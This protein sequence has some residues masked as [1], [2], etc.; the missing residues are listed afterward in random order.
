M[1]IPL[2]T[3]C[4]NI[5]PQSTS[6]VLGAGASVPSGA[7]SGAALSQSIWELV[8]KSSA[9]SDDLV[10]SASILERRFGR[11]AVI[12]AVQ[13]TLQSLSPCGGLLGLPAFPWRQLF[14]TNF[15]RLVELAYKS[16][17]VPLVAMRS[18]YDLST[19]ESIGKTVLYKIHGCVTQDRSLG[20]KPSMVLTEEDYENYGQFRQSLFS[21]LKTALLT[22]DILVI[23]QSL[24]DRHLS[25]LVKEILKAK[26]EGAPGQVYVL[27]YDKDDLRAPLLEDKGARIAFGGIDQFVDALAQGHKVTAPLA[28]SSDEILP[29]ELLASVTDATKACA[30]TANVLRMFNGGAA[31]YADIKAL[32]TFER[33]FISDLVTRLELGS[34]NFVGIVGAAGV[35]KTTLCR[36]I[37]SILESKGFKG[38]E[39][40]EDFPFRY[41]PWIRVEADLRAQGKRGIL[42]LDE[43]THY[44]RAM[45]EL[46]D[47]LADLP[48]SALKIIF[49]ANAAQWAP[50]IKSPNIFKKGK[51]VELSELNESDIRSLINLVEFNHSIAELVHSGFKAQS[52]DDQYTT[53]KRKSS[54]DMFV[55]LKNIFANESLDTILLREFDQLDVALQ[56]HYRYVSALQAVGMKVHR[57]LLIRMLTIEPQHVPA[58]LS[59]LT[60][61]IDEY[62][63]DAKQGIYGWRTRHLVIARRITD[64]KF[65]GAAELIKLFETIVDNIN[66]TVRTERDSISNICDAEFGIGRIGDV[67][68]RLLLYR[69]LTKLAPGER[70]PWH[71]VIRELLQSEQ[72][73]EAEYAIR[74]A[75]AAVGADAP[76]DRFKVRLLVIRAQKTSGISPSDRNALLRRAYE[77]SLRNLD[78]HKWDKHSYRTLVEVA[79]LLVERGVDVYLGDEALTRMRQAAKDICD[80]EMNRELQRLE[81]EHSRLIAS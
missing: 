17:G 18:N 52:R 59:G 48:D 66:P 64:Y 70:V 1:P 2:S 32:V 80:P 27:V 57:H 51:L 40:R 3:L 56:D 25:D 30:G 4:A 29:L 47:H 7:P 63:I 54:A 11:K 14:T 68:A 8:A 24:R 13:R 26:G 21:S 81:A 76:I 53:L 42:F 36:Q 69:K 33:R 22:G 58:I 50:R 31:T 60:G 73:D 75:E 19:R 10:E 44:L 65:S 74:D 38:W 49:A 37:V 72:L 5:Q 78:R 61:I 35:G 6:L 28:S 67:E 62:D 16:Q 43:C 46:V 12:E 77:I 9:Q 20:D 41:E 39:Q 15:D 71:R 45:N 23:G 79:L 55:C 34:Q